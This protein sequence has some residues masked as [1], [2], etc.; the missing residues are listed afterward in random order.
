MVR[1]KIVNIILITVCYLVGVALVCHHSICSSSQS[2][3]ILGAP[4][5]SSC[6]RNPP[7]KSWCK[8]LV[9]ILLNGGHWLLMHCQINGDFGF[10]ASGVKSKTLKLNV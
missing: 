4:N 10:F 6:P 1:I 2:I 8:K 7:R 5:L 3:E 9:S